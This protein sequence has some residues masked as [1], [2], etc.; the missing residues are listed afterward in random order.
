MAVNHTIWKMKPSKKKKKSFKLEIE[1][2]QN[3]LA[4]PTVRSKPWRKQ[5]PS[6]LSSTSWRHRGH[7][8][9]WSSGRWAPRTYNF[10]VHS[11]L[12]KYLL[13]VVFF[14]WR[15]QFRTGFTHGDVQVVRAQ[16]CVPRIATVTPGY[17]KLKFA[18]NFFC[19]QW[20]VK[21]QSTCVHFDNYVFSSMMC[22][23]K[24]MCID[25]L[26]ICHR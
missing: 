10:L 17:F 4:P 22:Y 23:I 11:F 15:R 20:C 13:Q 5:V 14:A 7:G 16:L 1:P 18:S 6:K 19:T 24:S 25:I 12:A 2:C 21:E 9:P 26:S 3:S 8:S